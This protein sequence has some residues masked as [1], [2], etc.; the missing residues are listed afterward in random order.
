MTEAN[1]CADSDTSSPNDLICCTALIIELRTLSA[2]VSSKA[3]C[4]KKKKKKEAKKKQFSKQKKKTTIHV[5]R[6]ETCEHQ[7]HCKYKKS[8]LVKIGAP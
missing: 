8:F 2:S 1:L 7:P 3:C 5:T 4:K 6:I